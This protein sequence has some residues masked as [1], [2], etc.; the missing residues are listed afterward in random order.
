V[1]GI[2]DAVF[3]AH[4]AHASRTKAFCWRV[5]MLALGAVAIDPAC[6]PTFWPGFSEKRA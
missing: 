4:A 3:V 5:A 1:P 6:P 2:P